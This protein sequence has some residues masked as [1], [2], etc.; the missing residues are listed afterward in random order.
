MSLIDTFRKNPDGSI[1]FHPLKEFFRSITFNPNP[2]N[3]IIILPAGGRSQLVPFTARDDG[4]IFLTKAMCT[5]TGDATIRFYDPARSQYWSNNEVHIDTV[6]GNGAQPGLLPETVFIQATQSLQFEV[7]NITVPAVPNTIEFSFGA[8]KLY[9]K[10]APADEVAKF[11]AQKQIQTFP[12]WLTPD[13]GFFTIPAGGVSQ[14]FATVPSNFDIE[15]FAIN[16][17]SD[18][19][20]RYDIRYRG[21]QLSNNAQV[22]DLVATGVAGFPYILPT[23]FVARRNEVLEINTTNL[24]PINPNVV[25][26]TMIG[27]AIMLHE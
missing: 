27:R 4:H 25:W 22:P 11:L 3:N 6:V 8:A 26:F 17:V 15:I 23:S 19:N 1:D 24:S 10:A 12:Y 7:R 2:P 18:E 5:R 14:Q 13:A 20:F 21:D 9:H 16:S